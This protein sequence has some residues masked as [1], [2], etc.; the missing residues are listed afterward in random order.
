MFY[1]PGPLFGGIKWLAIFLV[2]WQ[3]RTGVKGAS[4]SVD[5]APCGLCPST[6]PIEFVKIY[7]TKM[8]GQKLTLLFS[9]IFGNFGKKALIG[10]CQFFSSG[11]VRANVKWAGE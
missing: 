1:F 10:E 3:V 8:I 7:C 2:Y 4:V 6:L 5:Y 11:E 9:H